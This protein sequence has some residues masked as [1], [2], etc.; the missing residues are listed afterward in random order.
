MNQEGDEKMANDKLKTVV[1]TVPVTVVLKYHV[2]YTKRDVQGDPL[3]YTLNV[4]DVH[5]LDADYKD[6]DV[7]NTTP[8][9]FFNAFSDFKK[10]VLARVE[11]AVAQKS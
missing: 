8:A 4:V 6:N 11:R 7:S 2:D 5:F 3:G 10:S 1:V 9:E